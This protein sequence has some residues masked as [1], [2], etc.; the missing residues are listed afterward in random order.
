MSCSFQSRHRP[1][2]LPRRH[3]VGYRIAANHK[4]VPMMARDALSKRLIAEL[5]LPSALAKH[6]VKIVREYIPEPARAGSRHGT[7]PRMAGWNEC[8]TTIMKSMR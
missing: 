8:C 4:G 1:S 5:L 6:I 2:F 3:P 7:D